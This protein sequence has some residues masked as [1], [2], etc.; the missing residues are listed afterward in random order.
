MSSSPT[1]SPTKPKVS[2]G[3]KKGGGIPPG[4]EHL[5]AVDV[6][7]RPSPKD[8][9]IKKIPNKLQGVWSEPFNAVNPVEL[10]I[11]DTGKEPPSLLPSGHPVGA[12]GY[13][14]GAD[15]KNCAVEDMIFVPPKAK[16]P[17]SFVP[18]G[19]WSFPVMKRD[20]NALEEKEAGFLHIGNAK[21]SEDLDVAGTWRMLYHRPGE[22]K[23][24]PPKDMKI[25]VKKPN[26]EKITLIVKPENTVDDVKDMVKDRTAIPKDEQRLQ[27][28]GQPL[29]DKPTLKDYGIQDDDIL[30]LEPME[31]YV[32]DPKGRRYTLVV[33]PT[34]TIDQIK[35]KLERQEGIPKENQRLTFAGKPCEDSKN[36][37]NHGIKHK[38]VLHLEPMEIY[39]QDPKG[40]KYTLTV[41]PTDTIDQVKDKLERQEGIPKSR[42]RLTFEG[43]P[44]EDN[45][46]LKNHGIKHKS[47][48][49]L[50][51]MIVY[52]K[53]PKGKKLTFQVEPTD[54]IQ[55]I[56][57]KVNQSEGIPIDDQRLLFG[58]KPLTDDRATLE[59]EGIKHKDTID[60][61]PMHIIVKDWNGKTFNVPCEPEDTIDSIKN[62]I[63]KKEG[64]PK[65]NQILTFGPTFLDDPKKLKDYGIKHKDVVNLDRMKI[66]VK[67]W[68]GK[69]FPLYVDPEENIEDVK[70]MIEKNEGHPVADQILKFQNKKLDN[71]YNLDDYGIKHND[72]I[73]LSKAA[74]VAPPTPPQNTYTIQ[75][76]P[77]KSP[78]EAGYTSPTKSK[79]R[80]GIRAKS[81]ELL[82]SRWH[83]DLESEHAELAERAAE[84]HRKAKE[85]GSS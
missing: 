64:H 40:K 36:L 1:K 5:K 15:P 76:S 56:K 63:E 49:N 61:E 29:D 83:T 19:T 34:D 20:E 45:K 7:A 39:V 68:N 4:F 84:M 66:Y 43:K 24:P 47:V 13:K 59:K 79:K 12:W 77:Y 52:V 16:Q 17:K 32:Q 71:P 28:K 8:E 10:W 37:R 78:L 72:T 46:N 25:H 58:T 30:I 53:T 51:P 67:D 60:M 6:F 73:D 21:K 26:G 74:P 18:K 75:L 27:H 9:P 23:P 48:L 41:E 82:K 42:Q 80:D 31:I 22:D 50:E 55:E 62:K 33:E 2:P 14:P 35:N 11:F 38:S 54:T 44:C 65:K 81:K 70:K 57:R 3:I 69:T 85:E